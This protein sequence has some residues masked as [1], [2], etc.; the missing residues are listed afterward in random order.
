MGWAES[1]KWGV[2]TPAIVQ[3]RVRDDVEKKM[4]RNNNKMKNIDK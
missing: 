4:R 3:G 2:K 1:I